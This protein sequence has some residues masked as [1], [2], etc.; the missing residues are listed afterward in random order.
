MTGP[1]TT[2]SIQEFVSTWFRM[3]DTH[4]NVE[5]CS[6]MLADDGLYMR[7]PE[8]E[9]GDLAAF[10]GWYDRVTHLFFDEKHS[11]RSIEVRLAH[12]LLHAP[13]RL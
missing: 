6:S 4:A 3:L 13:F 12:R 1:I 8:V 10:R 2:D 9:I 7:F 11:I 5:T